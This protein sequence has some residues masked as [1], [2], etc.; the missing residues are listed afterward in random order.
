MPKAVVDWE[1]M[2]L[3]S[4]NG[5][6]APSTHANLTVNPVPRGRIQVTK[7]KYP[8]GSEWRLWDLHI[9]TPASFFWKGQKFTGEPTDPANYALVDEM[10]GA[11]NAAEPAVFAL[12]DY[13]TFDGWFALKNRLKQ[14]GAP[15]LEKTVFPGV[16]LRICSPKGRLNAHMVFSDCAS[17]QDL[18]DFLNGMKLEGI[19]KP[20]S[21][22]ALIEYARSLTTDKLRKHG[23]NKSEVTANEAEALK[24][25]CESAELKLDPYREALKALPSGLAVGFMPFSTNDGLAAIDPMEHYAYALSL[26]K[27]STI[28]EVR[29]DAKWNAFVGNKTP[30]NARFFDAFQEALGNQPRLPV[31]GSDAHCFVG[32][33]GDNDRRGYGDYPS[34]RGTWIKADPTWQGLLQAIKEPAKRCFIGSV[35]PKVEKVATNRTF[36][37]DRV[38]LKK[39]AGSVL[40]DK[41]FDGASIS[42]NQDL[43]AIIGNKGSGKSALADVL[44]LLGNS[45]DT[46]HFSFL[47]QERFR[48][49]SGEPARQ[50]E[51]RL[52]WLTGPS[53]TA[54]LADNPLNDRVE[55]I[56]YIPQGRF[57]ALCNDHVSGKSDAFEGELR[58]VI[59]DH[60]GEARM[61]ALSFDELTEAQEKGFRATLGEYRKNLAE[62]NRIIVSI[63]RHLHPTIKS[64]LEEQLKLKRLQLKEL[65]DAK[66]KEV[67]QPT[68]QLSA[69]QQAAATRL[70]EIADAVKQITDTEK[71]SQESQAVSRGR[72]QAAKNVV[73]RLQMLLGQF[74]LLEADTSEDLA[75][76]GLSFDALAK[77]SIDAAPLEKVIADSEAAIK[78]AAQRIDAGRATKKGLDAEGEKL[79]LTLNEPQRLHQAYTTALKEWEARRSTLVGSA[80]TPDSIT[81]IEKRLDQVRDLP[82]RLIER[83]AQRLDVVKLIYG[84]LAQ[85]REARSKLFQPLQDVIKNNELIREEYRLQFEANLNVFHEAVSETL[86]SLVKQNVGN[87]RGEDESRA[88]IKQRVD[89]VVFNDLQGALDFVQSV[90][91]LLEDSSRKSEAVGKGIHALMRKDRQP[92]EVYDYI[93]G[94]EY[95]EPKYTL[96]FQ[97]TPIEQLSP[98]QRGALLLIFYLL[99]DRGRNPIILDQPEEN[100]DN[101]TIVNLLVPVICEA[102]KNRQIIMV[103]HNPNLA[104]V[105]D[106]EQIIRATFDRRGKSTINYESGSIEDGVINSQ[107]V[108]VLEGTK[109]AFDNRSGKY[110]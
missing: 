73:D 100:L 44:A 59:F 10:I 29:D 20:L 15:K 106:A 18:K 54:N 56:K 101:E 12:M 65:D 103:T 88:E 63:E 45:K 34:G 67:A 68:D 51:G 3:T 66:P 57:E 76:I 69:E 13:W 71:A 37:I 36:Y 7:T 9:H 74:A 107:V 17:D 35:P 41:W 94:L 40:P 77:V 48:G 4:R 86:F 39:V 80:E 43:V 42:L 55:L 2:P 102:K 81:G 108:V 21:K 1:K 52:H 97:D 92:E 27:F 28:F 53:H 83:S 87:L 90:G 110:H 105:C 95:V 82:Q 49:R 84:V 50:F 104:V 24:A 96:L 70:K 30:R 11:L 32:V 6:A 47:R 61:G 26:F 58:S 8:K 19:E 109:D 72:A 23:Y 31:S 46:K 79:A 93:Y 38:E 14:T 99:V 89:Q 25:G 33:P 98:G 85:Q 22:A 16:E 75:K 60:L 91:T 78:D 64:N 5:C 62:L